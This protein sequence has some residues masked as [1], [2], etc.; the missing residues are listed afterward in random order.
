MKNTLLI[1]LALISFNSYAGYSPDY[2]GQSK[3]NQ[4][5]GKF[6]ELRDS[7]SLKDGQSGN[8]EPPATAK[9]NKTKNENVNETVQESSDDSRHAL[10]TA[11]TERSVSLQGRSI[12]SC[13]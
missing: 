12:S 4:T 10:Y 13:Y 2:Y 9:K 6:G 5:Y 11:D 7:D 1:A 3:S 8:C